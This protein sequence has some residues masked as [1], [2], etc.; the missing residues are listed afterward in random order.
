MY[1]LAAVA[2][3]VELTPIT[4]TV[5]GRQIAVVRIADDVYAFDAVCSHREAPL[6]DG[7]VT[8]KRTVLCPWHLGTFRITDGSVVAGP[9]RVGIRAYPVTIRDGTAYLNETDLESSPT[10]SH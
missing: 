9:P 1:R 6:A 4:L 10:R 5:Q 3:L 2:D 7:A 8:R